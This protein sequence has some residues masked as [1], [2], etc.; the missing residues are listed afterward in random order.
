MVSVISACMQAVVHC[1][2]LAC[3]QEIYRQ[4]TILLLKGSVLR[5]DETGAETVP[6]WKSLSLSMLRSLSDKDTTQFARSWRD[7]MDNNF[8]TTKKTL[9]EIGVSGIDGIIQPVRS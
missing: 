6:G 7:L 3:I 8:I 4:I 5:L 2:P 9:L 1:C